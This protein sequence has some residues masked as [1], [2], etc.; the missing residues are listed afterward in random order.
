MTVDHKSEKEQKVLAWTALDFTDGEGVME[1]FCCKFKTEEL[2]NDFK[3]SS[4]IFLLHPPSPPQKKINFI[5]VKRS[6]QSQ[7]NEKK[8]SVK[9]FSKGLDVLI[10]FPDIESVFYNI[11]FHK[12]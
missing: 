10:I 3:V 8:K 9:I 7:S 1:S 5:V 11:Y 12:Y 6:T 2:A 4:S